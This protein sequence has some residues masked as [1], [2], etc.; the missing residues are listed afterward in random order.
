MGATLSLAYRG[1]LDPNHILHDL[2]S[3]S[4]DTR[5]ARLRSRRLF[6]PAAQNF[7]DNLARLGIRVSGWTNHKWKTKYCEN[8]SRLRAFVSRTGARPVGMGLSQTAWV[9]LNTYELVLGSFTHHAQ[10]GVLLLH[11][12]ASAALLNKLQTMF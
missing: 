11:Q 2:L 3:G 5:Q 9:K 8:A 7:L 6:V 10:N 12:I 4:S 1:S